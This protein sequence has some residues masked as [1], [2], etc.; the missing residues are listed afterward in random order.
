MYGNQVLR[1]A[2]T[3]ALV[4]ILI[5]PGFFWLPPKCEAQD[6]IAPA[7]YDY[8]SLAVTSILNSAAEASKLTDIPQRV[9][10]LI[11]AAKVLPASQHEGAVRLLDVALSNVKEWGSE[12][13]ARWYQ[14]HTA[15][16]LRNEVLAVYAKLDPEKATALQREFQAAESTS[17]N[18]ATYNKNKYWFTQFTDR[19]PI[20][21]QAAKIAI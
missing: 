12:D 1:I 6:K 16:T 4:A 3:I 15:A 11:N 7:E 21:D 14:R 18:S 19:E 2:G 17:D 5:S 10:L 8:Y 13:K 9:N 20:S